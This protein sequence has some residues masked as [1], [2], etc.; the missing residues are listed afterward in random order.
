MLSLYWETTTFIIFAFLL[1]VLLYF[2]LFIL[3]ILI[4][5]MYALLTLGPSSQSS[6]KMPH[7]PQCFPEYVYMCLNMCEVCVYVH[8][9]LTLNSSSM[10]VTVSPGGVF[11]SFWRCE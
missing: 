7:K 6:L 1:L 10:A 5:I 8:P 11:V 4:C 9:R 3:N 2:S